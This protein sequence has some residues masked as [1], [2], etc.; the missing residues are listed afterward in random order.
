M[1]GIRT[2]FNNKNN[3]I[4]GIV[5]LFILVIYLGLYCEWKFIIPARDFMSHWT[6][7][8]AITGLILALHRQTEIASRVRIL[9]STKVQ[10]YTKICMSLLRSIDSL[11]STSWNRNKVLQVTIELKHLGEMLRECEKC[12]VGPDKKKFMQFAQKISGWDQEFR[13][14]N[15]D[16]KKDIDDIAFQKTI[17]ETRDL[18]ISA[19]E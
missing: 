16:L 1:R 10:A 13:I 15:K 2:F 7:F 9:T 6:P 4:W 5:W 8:A 12:C 18:L 14:K 19:I 3:V 11:A 17:H